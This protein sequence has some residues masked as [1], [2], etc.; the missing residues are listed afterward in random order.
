MPVRAG[1]FTLHVARAGFSLRVSPRD[2]FLRLH[3]RLF[4]FLILYNLIFWGGRRTSTSEAGS[5]PSPDPS[6]HSSTVD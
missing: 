2:V 5:P 1:V 4:F 3:A 6:L